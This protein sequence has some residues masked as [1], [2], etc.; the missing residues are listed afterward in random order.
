MTFRGN[1]STSLI[2]NPSL[3]R[4]SNHWRWDK[5]ARKHLCNENQLDAIFFLS[6]SCQ[7]TSTSF[8]HIC[9]PSSGGTV[10]TSTQQLVRVVLFSWLPV[11]RVGPTQ[12][13]EK[14]S[15]YQLLYIHSIPPDDGPQICPKHVE[16]HW[17]N[18]LRINSPSS[19]FSLQGCIKMHRQQNIKSR[20]VIWVTNYKPTLGNIPE[21]RTKP[22]G[23]VEFSWNMLYLQ[24]EHRYD[25]F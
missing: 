14:H 20:N 18:K 19:W 7:S 24:A 9:S 5:H 8:E 3:L 17:R 22:N 12:S 16:V 11:G 4:L 25:S 21:M 1:Q 10:Y 2:L 6:L 15:T 23:E 13:T